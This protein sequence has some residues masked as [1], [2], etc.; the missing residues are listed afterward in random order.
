MI[1]ITGELKRHANRKYKERPLSDI[2]MVV[3]HHSA[4]KPNTPDGKRDVNAFANYH[5]TNNGWPGIG[6]HY[7]VAPD[8]TV[9][10]T[11]PNN[12][13]SYHASGANSHSLG[14]CLVGSFDIDEVPAA[15]WGAAL[16]L[17]KELMV[18]YG[19]P[20]DRVI[21]HREVPASK[22]CPGRKFDMDRFREGLT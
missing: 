6:Y 19:V 8:G 20:V 22:T 10:K 16:E 9:Y 18:A 7:V 2:K 11:Q 1:D 17:V 5:V 4:T 14:V 21:G 15:Q 13:I 3:V 12:V